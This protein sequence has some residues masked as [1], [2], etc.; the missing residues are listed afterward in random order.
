[1]GECKVKVYPR[2]SILFSSSLGQAKLESSKNHE[3]ARGYLLEAVTSG[4]PA[5]KAGIQ[6]S[7]TNFT[8]NGH[9]VTIGGD[10]FIVY[11][12]QTVKSSDDLV[13]M[14]ANSGS[15]GQKVTLTVL[16]NGKQ[17]QVQITLGLRPS[18]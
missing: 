12:G 1:M 16:R 18:S 14:L 8:D 13:T 17:M 2:F 3:L 9:Q 4:G 11:Y 10:V 6:A 15:V 5:D 7:K